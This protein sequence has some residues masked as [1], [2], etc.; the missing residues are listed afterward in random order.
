MIFVQLTGLSGS[1]KSTLADAVK[2]LLQKNDYQV[3][4]IY[5]DLL[6]STI[7]AA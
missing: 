2:E 5:G 1:G 6:R 7:S 3:E 4:I